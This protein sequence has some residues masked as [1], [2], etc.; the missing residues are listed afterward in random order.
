MRNSRPR[1]AR[2]RRKPT[3]LPNGLR[4]SLKGGSSVHRSY[5]DCNGRAA[6]WWQSFQQA[7]EP[8]AAPNVRART[9]D[10]QLPNYPITQLPNSPPPNPSL[11]LQLQ[12]ISGMQ[13]EGACGAL[14]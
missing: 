3:S 5:H 1:S 6:S 4:L 12:N 11:V 13:V 2:L 7:S 14:V 9:S 8:P 10:P